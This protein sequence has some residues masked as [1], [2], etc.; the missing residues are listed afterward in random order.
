MFVDN[1]RYED[2]DPKKCKSLAVDPA[3]GL[4]GVTPVAGAKAALSK[5]KKR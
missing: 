4:T 5:D 2:I 1:M 3:E